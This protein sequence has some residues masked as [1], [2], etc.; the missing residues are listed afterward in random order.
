MSLAKEMLKYRQFRRYID[1]EKLDL[2]FC[3]LDINDTGRIEEEDFYQIVLVLKLKFDQIDGPTFVQILLPEFSRK[4]IYRLIQLVVH[5]RFFEYF[6]DV[7]LVVMAILT[8]VECTFLLEG[9]GQWQGYGGDNGSTSRYVDN[10]G[11][12]IGWHCVEGIFTFFFVLEMILR[13]MGMGWKRY[14]QSHA[15]DFFVTIAS[16]MTTMTLFIPLNKVQ[17]LMN[18]PEMG[19]LTVFPKFFYW[20]Q[21]MQ[22]PGILRLLRMIA[23]VSLF[24]VF[25][26]TLIKMGQPAKRLLLV[27]FCSM[28]IFSVL[29]MHLFGGLVS[30]DSEILKN[31]SYG[32]ND[33]YS[34]NMND[35]MS[36][37]T[38]MLEL[39]VTNNFQ[40]FVDAY[41]Q[42]TGTAWT[43]MFFVIFYI[44]GDIMCLNLVLSTIITIF[45]MEFG[46]GT[47]NNISVADVGDG[48]D[49]QVQIHGNTVFF[50]AV[51]KQLGYNGQFRATLRG[52][53]VGEEDKEGLMRNLFSKKSAKNLLE[54]LEIEEPD[55]LDHLLGDS[56]KGG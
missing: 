18:S 1:T 42:L 24:K 12:K 3:T 30:R 10:Y 44:I 31:A 2:F 20:C 35:M 16:I 53:D 52:H 43:R 50:R 55:L 40:I 39:L 29:G 14:W 49:E 17:S 51:N 36:S 38:L 19:V 46:Q 28:Y 47:C 33:Y 23:T 22:V 56:K 15:F 26:V 54:Q 48:V 21:V 41:V 7:V 11:N 6:I 5:S 37:M 13:V 25:S 32:K 8:F 34:I 45:R 4:K 9:E 27:M